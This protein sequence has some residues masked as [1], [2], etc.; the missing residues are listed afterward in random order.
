MK[1]ALLVI[2][3]HPQAGQTKTRLTPP[4]T[5]EDAASLYA[6]FLL[7]TLSLVRN[8][9]NVCRFILYAP[10]HKTAYFQQLAPDFKLLGQNGSNLGARLDN[11]LNH[12]LNNGYDQV[13][14][15]NSDGPTLPQTYLEQAFAYLADTEVVFGPSEDGGYYLIGLTRPQPALVRK[16]RMSTS[17]VLEDTLAIAQKKEITVSLLPP[18]YDVDTIAELHR[19]RQELDQTPGLAPNSYRFL[20]T[21]G[22]RLRCNTFQI[23]D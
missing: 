4:L 8:I 10:D 22:L 7:D 23:S 15:M 14:I 19:L 2:A 11:A 13:V 9:S 16:V 3:K 12:C 5:P 21:L 18:W 17:T 6:C 20:K 1:R